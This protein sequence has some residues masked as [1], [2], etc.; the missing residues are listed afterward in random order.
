M[1]KNI[2]FIL[3]VVGTILCISLISG[4]IIL[5][6]ENKEKW[7]P[8]DIYVYNSKGYMAYETGEDIAIDILLC[9]LHRNGKNPM[10]KYE[11]V[12]FETDTGIRYQSDITNDIKRTLFDENEIISE[13]VVR[14]RLNGSFISGNTLNF[15]KLILQK[16]DG[17]E[18]VRDF[19]NIVIDIL[20][21]SEIKDKIA[22]EV[23]SVYSAKLAKFQYT[24]ENRMKTDIIVQELY[25]GEDISYEAATV[26]V[27]GS[28]TQEIQVDFLG[29]EGFNDLPNYFI[30]KPKFKILA[31]NNQE[32]V[33]SAAGTTAYSG[34]IS[35]A[36]LRRYL[37]DCVNENN[38]SN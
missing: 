19:G 29:T 38:I 13:S 15:T 23:P 22:I 10:E 1:N 5:L 12:Y 32:Y 21:P 31:D 36:E 34:N 6:L 33:C 30:I 9:S 26:L 3:A 14:F 28:E 18:I 16:K 37:L 4:S 27:A 35:N 11:N 7:P 8:D 17:T 2:K 25:L 20:Q 24:I